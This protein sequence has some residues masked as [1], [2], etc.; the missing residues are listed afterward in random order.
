MELPSY[1][2][3]PERSKKLIQDLLNRVRKLDPAAKK[4]LAELL[5][6]DADLPMLDKLERNY[7]EKVVTTLSKMSDRTAASE[8]GNTLRA[9][10]NRN[11]VQQ[12][13]FL[14][15]CVRGVLRESGA[16]LGNTLNYRE[17]ID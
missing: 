15:D 5:D 11:L 9:H 13:E 2:P 1:F 4:R 17:E 3:N 12:R 16:E 7:R 14:H 6:N 10:F 8:L